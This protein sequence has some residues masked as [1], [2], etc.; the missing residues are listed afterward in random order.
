MNLCARLSVQP[1]LRLAQAI[2][3]RTEGC[4]STDGRPMSL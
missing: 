3:G 2:K 1:N 4:I